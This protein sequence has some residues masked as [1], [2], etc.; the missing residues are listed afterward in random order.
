MT[1]ATPAPGATP[2]RCRACGACGGRTAF[3]RRGFRFEDCAQ[4]GVRFVA[5]PRPSV[6]DYD[7][8][9][10]STGGKDG[11]AAYLADRELLRENFAR[12][13]RWL[14]GFAPSGRLL[15]VGAAYGLFVAAARDAGFDA[16]GL[17]PAADCAE[18]ARREFGVQVET[19]RIETFEFAEKSFD[20]VTM[21]DVIEHLEDPCAV[22]ERAARL[23]RP[24]GLLV[25]ETGD[26]DALCARVCGSRWYFYDP[27]QH[28]TFFGRASLSRML[29]GAGFSA[30]LGFG[31][32]GRRVSVQNFAF[33]LGRALGDGPLG[34]TS[35]RVAASAAGNWSFAVPDRGNAFI[36]A[37][38]YGAGSA[39]SSPSVAAA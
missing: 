37:Y 33:Q 23:L 31:T 15:D 11:Y 22:V 9:Y 13:V 6:V 34:A 29:A 19:G 30:P 38:R 25:V 24:G 8:S 3:L 4:C 7:A 1:A 12:R 26:R 5:E 32:L 17:E 35:R 14:R 20:V 10:F 28:L 39:T 2:V 21:L 16:V 27:P 18:V 36:G